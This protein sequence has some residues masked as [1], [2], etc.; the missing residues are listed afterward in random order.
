MFFIFFVDFNLND[1]FE[2]IDKWFLVKI[3]IN[4]DN[5]DILWT[6]SFDK[7][8]MTKDGK[9]RSAFKKKLLNNWGWHVIK[10]ATLL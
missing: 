7:T 8:I 9:V 5:V 3:E 2:Y 6:S 1:S 4:K 10:N